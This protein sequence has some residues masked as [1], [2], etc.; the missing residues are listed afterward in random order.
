MAS[1]RTKVVFQT[2][3]EDAIKMA[4]EI[5]MGE[6][7]YEE[8]KHALDKP[9]ATGEY[10]TIVL[11]GEGENQQRSKTSITS[12]A[13]S[14]SKSSGGEGDG[15][16]SEGGSRAGSEAEAVAYGKS[17]GQHE[18]REMRYKTMTGGLYTKDEQYNRAAERIGTLENRHAI[19][20]VP[21]EKTHEIMVPEVEEGYANDGRV[22]R[23]KEQAFDRADFARPAL[24]ADEE[25][26]KRV[27][28]LRERANF[29]SYN[30]IT[31]DV[32]EEVEVEG[33][34]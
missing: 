27:E 31:G 21:G 24:L 15:A 16:S 8:P 29:A 26:N 1:A 5:H 32:I 17:K 4:P 25:I 19:V 20:K 28:D 23:F 12:S 6:I 11:R 18:A 33:E 9:A 14:W 13:D 10:D 2:S 30:P 3:Y 7:D 34:R 22:E